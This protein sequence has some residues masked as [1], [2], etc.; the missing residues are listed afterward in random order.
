MPKPVLTV[1]EAPSATVPVSPAR[2]TRG[3]RPL[4]TRDSPGTEESKLHSKPPQQDTKF[5]MSQLYISRRC[6]VQ[7]R[8]AYRKRANNRHASRDLKKGITI[9]KSQ[10]WPILAVLAQFIRG[11][12]LGRLSPSSCACQTHLTTHP[13]GVGCPA[14]HK[15]SNSLGWAGW[16]PG[17]ALTPKVQ[18]GD[19]AATS[20]HPTP[21]PHP[22]PH[23]CHCWRA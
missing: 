13:R 10:K 9:S 12:N 21:H 19:G 4:P 22:N 11:C 1:S 16:N 14:D 20:T 8:T 17:H 15:G 23:L 2:R 7:H 5:H 18:R 6:T 3:Y